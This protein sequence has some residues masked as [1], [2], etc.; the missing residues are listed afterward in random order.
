MKP[1]RRILMSGRRPEILR[2][3]QRR[4][5]A[6]V[7]DA[8]EADAAVEVEARELRARVVQMPAAAKVE[9]LGD[10]EAEPGRRREL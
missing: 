4:P 3:L 1:A 7:V 10:A 2:R 9:D 6:G 5:A 8:E